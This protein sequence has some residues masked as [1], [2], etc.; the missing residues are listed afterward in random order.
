MWFKQQGI[1][2]PQIGGTVRDYPNSESLEERSGV[3][4]LP[5]VWIP[6]FDVDVFT[7]SE[8]NMVSKKGSIDS[9]YY[10]SWLSHSQNLPD[11][12]LNINRFK[13]TG[14]LYN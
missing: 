8:T 14:L 9:V 5:K 2:K 3:S 6:R 12:G 10:A 7:V 1:K 13:Y 11:A 4:K